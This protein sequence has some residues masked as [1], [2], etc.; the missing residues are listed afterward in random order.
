MIRINRFCQFF[1]IYYVHVVNEDDI[2]L[3]K[4]KQ[5]ILMLSDDQLSAFEVIYY[6]KYI[7]QFTISY[8][9]YM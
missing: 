5:T 8:L 9:K 1:G 2:E 7:Q 4:K 3:K 6:W